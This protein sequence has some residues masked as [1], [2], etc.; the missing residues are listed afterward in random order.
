[1]EQA[2]TSPFEAIKHTREDG[3]E[4]WSGRDLARILQYDN[5]RNFQKVVEKAKIACKQS[6]QAI[7]DHIVDVNDMI[8]VGK[9]ARRKLSDMHLSRYF[10]YLIVQNADPEKPIVALGQTY[11]AVQTRRQEIEDELRALPE[12]Q[13][14][15]V[16]REQMAI[17][18]KQLADAAQRAGVVQPFDFAI[19]QDHGYAGLY[20]GLSARAIHARK[21]LPSGEEI[22]DWMNSDELAANAFR[23]SLTRQKIDREAITSKDDANE[24]HH[25]MGALVRKTIQDAGATLP[26]DMPTPAKSIQEIEREEQKRLARQ[27]Q[28]LLFNE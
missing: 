13:Q 24:A 20:G 25:E 26:E 16:R 8:T 22:L 21:Q 28:P 23:A 10:C 2:H 6:S 15:L 4:Y 3:S 14:R 12:N 19:F 5:Y 1:M 17:L 7:S 18:N 27:H 11:F 9:G